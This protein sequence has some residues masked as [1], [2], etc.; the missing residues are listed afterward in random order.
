MPCFHNLARKCAILLSCRFSCYSDY[1][2]IEIEAET[3]S[4]KF[5]ILASNR[6]QLLCLT[7]KK[8]KYLNNKV[9]NFIFKGQ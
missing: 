5:Y 4:I 8:R 6:A 2:F 1:A 3:H 7:E 9:N